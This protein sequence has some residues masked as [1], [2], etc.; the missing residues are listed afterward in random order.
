MTEAYWLVELDITDPEAYGLYVAAN[1]LA[2]AK[3]G[4]KFLVRSGRYL[5]K[6]G[7]ARERH[8]VIVFKDYETALACYESPEYARA[9]A[10]RKGASV[11]DLVIV[12]G[13]DGPQPASAPA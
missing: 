1:T 3:Y 12:E 6:E 2:F 11:A 10:L 4:G 8:A 9:R 13:Y 5:V 7:A